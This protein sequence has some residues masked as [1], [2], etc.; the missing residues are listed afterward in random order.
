MGR[1]PAVLRHRLGAPLL[2]L[3]LLVA[4]SALMDPGGTLGTDTGAKVIT[5]E[6]MQRNGTARPV[7]GYWAEEWDPT[8]AVH[9]LYQAGRNDDGEWVI[10][11]TLPMLEAARP[12]YELGGY[13]LALLLPML[14]TVGCALVAR[15]LAGRMGDA[16]DAVLA[17]WVVGAASP[18]L[19]Y[20][21]DL[22]EHSVGVAA[23]G[24]AV[25]LLVDHLTRGERWWRPLLAGGLLG[26]AATLRT[27]AIVYTAVAVGVV[28]L[29]LLARRRV[30]SAAALG[31]L[32]AAGFAGPWLL[33]RWMEIQLGG[34]SRASRAGGAVEAA[35]ARLQ[36]RVDQAL[37]MTLG[38]KGDSI[39]SI[40]IGTA[41][42]GLVLLGV[43]AERGGDRRLALIVV[44]LAGVPL[45][46]GAVSGLAFVPGLLVAFPLA[47][48]A[49]TSRPRGPSA[50][51]VAIAVVALPVVWVT[52]Y[53][54]GGGPQWGSRY[55]LV[56]TLLLAVVAT[57]GL[58]RRHPVVGRGVL[59]LT[60]G[61]SV[62]SVVW[63]GVRS[64]S[65]DAL[66][67]DLTAVDAEVVIARNGFLLREGGAATVG[68]PWLS[69]GDEEAFTLA[70]EVAEAA[71]ARR[72]AVVEYGAAA[73]P[74]E[75]VPDGWSEAT[76]TESSLA[77][78]G[79]GIVVYEVPGAG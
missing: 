45:L 69:T 27:E 40:V 63:L 30:G 48:L 28:G 37:V 52:A 26:A 53:V 24:A 65:V 15:S 7:V 49:L 75:V 61:V 56:S 55:T 11:T 67:E 21:L 32:A 16:D 6:T 38:A 68:Q 31:A 20:G 17:F 33:N 12:L 76:R 25:V 73:P 77:G 2:L 79:I 36:E 60:A 51:L 78:T 71:G 57:V 50:W 14:G 35:G 72:V 64:R 54:G 43:R 70:T 23:C 4:L 13:R 74:D 8:G 42:V 9:P 39:G 46:V 18:L 66:F 10:V 19:L 58:L 3:G 1:L 22:W 44:A 59:V 41:V 34:Q 5:L 62:L 47:V 29:V